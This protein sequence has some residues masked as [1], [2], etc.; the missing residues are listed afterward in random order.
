MVCVWDRVVGLFGRS[1]CM[2]GFVWWTGRERGQS[3]LSFWEYRVEVEQSESSYCF[4]TS[5]FVTH[6]TSFCFNFHQKHRICNLLGKVLKSCSVYSKDFFLMYGESYKTVWAIRHLD[7]A[8]DY[9]LPFLSSLPSSFSL[10]LWLII[11]ISIL[12]W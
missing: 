3:C 1:A 11:F 9:T 2:C 7:S 10:S 8:F 5:Q 6:Q 4:R 12:T